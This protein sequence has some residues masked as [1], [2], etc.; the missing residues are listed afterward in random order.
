MSHRVKNSLA[1][2]VGLLRV[3]ALSAQSEDLQS[4]LADAGSRVATIA[5]VHDHLWRGTQI[6]FVELADFMGEL[7]NKLQE[8]APGHAVLCHAD[9]TALSADQAIPLGLL[10]NELVTNAIKYAYPDRADAIHVSAR[11]IGGRLQVEV[12]D[13]GIGLPEGFDIDQPRKSLGLRLING[14]LRQLNGQLKIASNGPKGS[15]FTLDMPLQV[16]TPKYGG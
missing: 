2:V 1:V 4:A 8:T 16:G 7:C 3:Q 6:G 14:L 13:Q 12:S 5:Q 9:R 11:T 15:R 10:V